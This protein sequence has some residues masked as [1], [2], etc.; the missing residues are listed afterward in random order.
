M[1]ASQQVTKTF[2][3]LTSAQRAGWAGSIRTYVQND[4]VVNLIANLDV[5]DADP[6]N[7]WKST[8]IFFIVRQLLAFDADPATSAHITNWALSV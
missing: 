1:K 2:L 7:A 4:Q 6:K 5:N 8:N 3:R